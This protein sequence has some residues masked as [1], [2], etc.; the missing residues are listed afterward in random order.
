[1]LFGKA[2]LFL[3]LGAAAIHFSVAEVIGKKQPTTRA[4]AGAWLMDDRFTA[5][6]WA[7]EDIF[8]FLAPIFPLQRLSATWT[9]FAHD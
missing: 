3:A 7:F 1:M 2:L 4:F 6:N 9:F 8:A 5:G